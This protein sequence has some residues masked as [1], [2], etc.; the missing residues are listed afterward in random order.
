MSFLPQLIYRLNAV[1]IKF[2]AKFLVDLDKFILKFIWKCTRS[3]I[4]KI[5][6]K[7]RNKVGAITLLNIKPYYIA[8]VSKMVWY[9]QGI[10]PEINR[11]P[12]YRPTH[13]YPVAI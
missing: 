8:T 9:W 5:I 3:R 11:E 10:D 6:L 13:I 1:S 12:R 4:A 7:K 2:L